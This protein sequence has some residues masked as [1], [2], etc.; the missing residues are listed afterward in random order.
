MKKPTCPKPK[1]FQLASIAAQL[2]NRHNG[3][4]A[5]AAAT[6]VQIWEACA[7]EIEAWPQRLAQRKAEANE[8]EAQKKEFEA[9]K[10]MQAANPPKSISNFGILI[11]RLDF[12]RPDPR[13]VNSKRVSFDEALVW[14]MPKVA[15]GK[16]TVNFRKALMAADG[17]DFI[18]AGD[19]ITILQNRKWFTEQRKSLE[20]FFVKWWK[21]HLTDERSKAG[22]IRGKKK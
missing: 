1:P 16:R 5:T 8:S 11:Q 4:A 22:H 15:K 10:K 9:L 19:K 3:D 17:S 7:S 6:A 18:E 13:L 20:N 2:L 12:H 14:I 21:K